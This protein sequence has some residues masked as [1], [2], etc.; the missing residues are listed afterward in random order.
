[1]KPL[2]RN[3]DLLL[4]DINR[5]RN[6][7][8]TLHNPWIRW[9]AY[10]TGTRDVRIEGGTITVP[11]IHLVGYGPTEQQALKMAKESGYA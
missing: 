11:N 6:E 10:N 8:L 3:M 1:M 9:Q 2:T 7:K 5:A 4:G